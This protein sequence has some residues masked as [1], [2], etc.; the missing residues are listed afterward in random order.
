[1]HSMLLLCMHREA[2]QRVEDRMATAYR[3]ALLEQHQARAYNKMVRVLG[4]ASKMSETKANRE[5]VSS[6]ALAPT[7]LSSRRRVEGRMAVP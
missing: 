7:D 3:A 4:S 6:V 5:M 1:M 2:Q